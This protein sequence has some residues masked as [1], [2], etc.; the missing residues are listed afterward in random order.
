MLLKLNEIG[1][2]MAVRVFPFKTSISI[3]VIVS[4]RE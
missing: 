4:N 2:E 3:K 1:S